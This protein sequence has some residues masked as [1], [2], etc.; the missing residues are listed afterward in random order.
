MNRPLVLIVEDEPL[1]AGE[2][3]AAFLDIGCR[4]SAVVPSGEEA[5]AKLSQH[6]AD[7]VLMDI[8]LRGKLDGIETAK[9]I[10]RRWEIPVAFLTAFADQGVRDLAL[11]TQPVAVLYKPVTREQLRQLI[12]LA[13]PPTHDSNSRPVQ[14]SLWPC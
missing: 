12:Y 8:V 13:Y 9:E 1:V 4:V 7:L 2:L 6:R 11:M 3:K 5:L 14:I 10:R